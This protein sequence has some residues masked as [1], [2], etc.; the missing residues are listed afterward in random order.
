MAYGTF[1][2]E[3]NLLTVRRTGCNMTVHRESEQE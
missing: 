1:T 3:L 2:K